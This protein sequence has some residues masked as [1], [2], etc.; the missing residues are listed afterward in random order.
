MAEDKRQ[1]FSGGYQPI[2]KGFQGN[3]N[4]DV[5]NPPK[6]GTGVPSKKNNKG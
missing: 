4:V 3:G 1:K 5:K 2:E 6:S